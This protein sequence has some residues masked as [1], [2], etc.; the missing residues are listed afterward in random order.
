MD[1]LSHSR[2]LLPRIKSWAAED[3]LDIAMFKVSQ[4][5]KTDKLS[6]SCGGPVV[7]WSSTWHFGPT[8]EI[9]MGWATHLG[10]RA[11]FV[12]PTRKPESRM[13]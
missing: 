2:E 6:L 12:E 11:T 3:L 5:V 7:S 8:R 1:V 10:F 13:K 9:S 4:R